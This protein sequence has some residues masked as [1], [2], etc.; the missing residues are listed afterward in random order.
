M[1][2]DGDLIAIGVLH[3]AA[4]ELAMLVGS[5]RRRLWLKGNG[6]LVA[7]GVGVFRSAILL[8]DFQTLAWGP[9]ENIAC[10]PPKHGPA[11]GAK[12]LA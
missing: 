3:N 7:W 9:E 5:V 11:V 4:R 1:A 2:E 6:P 8:K 12:L 10:E